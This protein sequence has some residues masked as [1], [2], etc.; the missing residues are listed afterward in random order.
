MSRAWSVLIKFLS[1]LYSTNKLIFCKLDIATHETVSSPDDGLVF[2]KYFPAD[3]RKLKKALDSVDFQLDFTLEDVR[4]K[5]GS[6]ALLYLTLFDDEIIGYCWWSFG[7][8]YLPYCGWSIFLNDDESYCHNNYVS[9]DFR[10]LNILN[11]M[12]SNAFLFLLENGI[13]VDWLCYYSW[14]KAAARATE[15]FGYKKVC[16]VY[17]GYLLTIKYVVIFGE[18]S[19]LKFEINFFDLWLKLFKIIFRADF[20]KF[21]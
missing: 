13:S 18:S 1:F 6:G 19:N 10:G 9:K 3:Y 8:I 15:K 7:V 4:E 11:R 17:Y 21:K 2:R 14:N 16:S 20:L 5:T 12:R